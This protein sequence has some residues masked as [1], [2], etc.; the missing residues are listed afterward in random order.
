MEPWNIEGQLIKVVE[1][2]FF[3]FPVAVFDEFCLYTGGY[4]CTNLVK[5]VFQGLRHGSRT[6]DTRGEIMNHLSHIKWISRTGTEYLPENIVGY[7]Y[8]YIMLTD[9]IKQFGNAIA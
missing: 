5:Q 8:V 4:V 3:I 7:R 9:A 6:R 1:W 2:V